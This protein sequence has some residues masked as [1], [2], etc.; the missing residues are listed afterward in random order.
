[1][2]RIDILVCHLSGTGH[3]VRCMR[4]ARAARARGHG[5]RVISGGRPLA[6]L[7][8]DD[9]VL[10]QLP[11]VAI[12]GLDFAT[13]RMPDGAPVTDAFMADRQ[14]RLIA[15]LQADPPDV[16]ITETF[17][18]GRRILAAEFL[19]AIRAASRALV[20]A[21]VRDIPEPKPK[22][23]D[24]A[25]ARLRAHFHGV[26]VHG[27]AGL[28]PLRASWPLPADLEPMIHHVGYIAPPSPTR[29]TPRG[30]TVLVSGGGGTL[31]RRLFDLAARA[32]AL[33]PRP[34]HLLIGGAD[35]AHV[36]RTL[37]ATHGRSNLL[38][39][40][41]RRDYPELLARAAVSVSLCGYNTA[42]ELA[43]Q[44]VPAILVPS[45][46]GGEQEQTLRARALSH[47]PG[48]LTLDD[49]DKVTPKALA[50]TA[51]HMAAEGS[52]PAIPLRADD[53]T[54]AVQCI[55]TLLCSR[56]SE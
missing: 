24:E 23:L 37:T 43:A 44:T 40:P 3:L 53:G 15:H 35:G 49:L 5:V 9:G 22:R 33:D 52:R 39:E 55:E 34:W 1:M 56:T 41:V 18:L 16:L 19:S 13:L 48:V 51:A 36:A 25:A 27:D 12:Q 31:G 30:P 29:T 17:P 26:L 7:D 54:A 8:Q 2:A 50:D 11:P 21:S 32:A 42:V 10:V 47:H 6:H 14:D 28:I 4:L 46:E 45:T 38:I 20:L